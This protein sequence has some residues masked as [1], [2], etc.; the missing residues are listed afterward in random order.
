MMWRSAAARSLSFAVFNSDEF[1]AARG[2]ISCFTS[3][4]RLL[5]GVE[6]DMTEPLRRA[7]VWSDCT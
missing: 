2:A 1:L 3:R 5:G 4:R 6:G 7:D